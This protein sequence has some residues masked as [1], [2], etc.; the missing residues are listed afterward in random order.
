MLKYLNKIFQIF[1][2]ILIFIITL[3]VFLSLY[4]MISIKVLHKNQNNIFGITIYEIVSGSM[5]PTIN[6][7]DLIV[8][9]QTDKIKENDIIT[10]RDNNDFITHR[11]IKI[12]GD[13]LTT[14]GDSNNST[15]TKINKSKIVGKVLLIIPK[16]GII[17]EILIKPKV[18]IS[19]VITLILFSLCSSYIPKNKREKPELIELEEP[20]EFID[21]RR[22]K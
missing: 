20:I 21:L 17:R 8:V 4:N 1:I 3:L 12:E 11:V 14:K 22:R 9:S 2:D 7:K 19:I 18:I 16:G 15:D 13:I 5:E 10:Y 6:V